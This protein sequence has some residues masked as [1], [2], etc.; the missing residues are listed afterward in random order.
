MTL[1]AIAMGGA[2]GAL[3][4]YTM[5]SWVQGMAGG[6]F[7][8]GTWTVNAV[9]SLV[10]GFV[11][12]WLTHSLASSELR[13]FVV[14]GFLGSFTTFSTFSFETIEMLQ[15]GLWWRAGFYSLGSVALGLLAVVAGAAAANSIF[16]PTG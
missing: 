14:M 2:L 10:L 4:R 12:I 13:H 5:G 6:A 11:M 7:P 9:G 3:S 16:R 1:V 8:W 15:E